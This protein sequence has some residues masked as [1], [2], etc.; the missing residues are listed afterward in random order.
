MYIQSRMAVPDTARNVTPRCCMQAMDLHSCQLNGA[1]CCTF[2]LNS[3][4]YISGNHALD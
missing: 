4:T 2:S 3:K 1:D